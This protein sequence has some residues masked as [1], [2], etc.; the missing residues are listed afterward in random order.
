MKKLFFVFCLLLLFCPLFF[1]EQ[2]TIPDS[3]ENRVKAAKRYLK[4]VP[5]EDIVREVAANRALELP[6]D[7]QDEFIRLMQEKSRIIALENAVTSALTKHFTAGELETL[8]AFYESS[9][10]KSSMT[11]FG[12]YAMDIMASIEE[13]IGLVLSSPELNKTH[14]LWSTR[15][16]EFEADFADEEI[17]ADY[18]FTNTGQYSVKI[19][20]V[21]TSCGCTTV[22]LDKDVYEPGEKGKITAIFKF[23]DRIGLQSELIKVETMEPEEQTVFLEL[24]VRIP[25]YLH[26]KP[27]FLFW[28]ADE[29]LSSKSIELS[30]P[31][32]S[33]TQI[34]GVETDTDFFDVQLIMDKSSGI[35][36]IQVKP[37]SDSDSVFGKLFV[38][39]STGQGKK[40]RFPVYLRVIP[41]DAD[42]EE[43]DDITTWNKVLWIDT[44][45]PTDYEE[46]HLPGALLLNEDFWDIQIEQVLKE[47]TPKTRIVVYCHSSCRSYQIA[48]RLRFY[49][50]EQVYIIVP[51]T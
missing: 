1:S 5:V 38:S 28:Y 46:S 35:Y 40:R 37:I 36:V 30:I 27:R 13:E 3:A 22:K 16:H 42:P 31:V 4:A 25:E 11:K 7:Q 41:M 9:E 43:T 51:R 20:S 24:R 18:E 47:W 45:S 50:L 44:G 48:E 6:E 26:L 2:V 19:V 14:L 12:G 21:S 39:A 10:G 29:K 33:N 8:A 17:I 15:I 34:L 32:D 49:G 23:N